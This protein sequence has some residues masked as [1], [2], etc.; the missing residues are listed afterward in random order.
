MAPGWV[1][2]GYGWC[3]T[4]ATGIVKWNAGSNMVVVDFDGD[5]TL[6]R[7]WQ[8]NTARDWCIATYTSSSH[9]EQENRFRAIFPLE[10]ELKTPAQHKGALASSQRL[11]A[12]L[13]LPE[14]KDNC[15]QKAERLWFGNTRAE[16]NHNPGALVPAFL[17]NDIDYEE[18]TD[19]TAS[20]ANDIDVR[21]C[22]WL[23]Q[24]FLRPSEDGEYESY[25]VPVMAACAGVGEP[26]F[27]SWVD[28]VLVVI[29]VRN[30]RTL[31]HLNGEVSETIPDTLHFIR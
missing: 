4:H 7:F 15:G 29:T 22:Q 13:E 8:T 25:Y 26:L 23:L 12:E 31:R 28:W 20:D 14:L 24:N 5:T 18:A 17:L 21:R 30:Q 6:G 16:F 2:A 10:L 27:D 1:A 11:L 19:F 9:T 3:A